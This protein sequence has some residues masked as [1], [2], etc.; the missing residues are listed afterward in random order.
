MSATCKEFSERES[1]YDL[2]QDLVERNDVTNKKIDDGRANDVEEKNVMRKTVKDLT[3][4]TDKFRGTYDTFTHEATKYSEKECS[5]SFETCMD[6]VL[7]SRG[8]KEIEGEVAKEQME[9]A[10][11]DRH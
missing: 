6:V 10:E 3:E 8:K 9:V 5:K 11:A 1:A 7:K 4:K 2:R